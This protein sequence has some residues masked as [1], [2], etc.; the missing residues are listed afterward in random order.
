MT[1]YVAH[2]DFILKDKIL[3]RIERKKFLRDMLC[4]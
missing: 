4:I 3:E 2:V 1:N